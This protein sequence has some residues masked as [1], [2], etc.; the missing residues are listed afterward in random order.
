MCRQI[1]NDMKQQSVKIKEWYDEFMAKVA[2]QN[3]NVI[4]E[5][6]RLRARV[7]SAETADINFQ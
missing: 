1:S 7:V 5:L 6:D 2:A 4:E 3:K